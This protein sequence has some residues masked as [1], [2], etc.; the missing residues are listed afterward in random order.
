MTGK[1]KVKVE[2]RSCVVSAVLAIATGLVLALAW[3]VNA[4]DPER[5]L[6][7]AA[8]QPNS[9]SLIVRLN[10]GPDDPTI[11]PAL[12]VTFTSSYYGFPS[13][14]VV[15]QLFLG[16]V[17]ADEETGEII[18]ELAT[19]WEMSSDATVFTFTLRSD[20]T[21]TDGSPV[22]AYDVRYG[23]LRSLDPDTNAE[24]E[25]P[26]FVIQNA[27]EYNNGSITDPNQVG[28][29]VLN[30]TSMRFTLERPAA[31]LPSVLAMPLAHAMPAWAITAHPT[32]WTEPGNIVTNGPY[33]LTAWSHGIS[34]ILDK[35]TSYH[36]A[37][38]VQIDR[39]LFSMVDD[40]TAWG[41]YLA[42]Q[43]DSVIV[44][45]D[46]W[47]AAQS[48]PILQ[49]EIHYAPYPCTYYYGFN[50]AKPPFDDLLVRKAFIA[51]VDR[52][53]VVDN[54]TRYAQQPALTFT[55][56][57]VFGHVDGAAEAVGIPYDPTQAQQWLAAAGYPNGQGLPLITLMYNTLSR[58]EDIAEY[59]RQNW[60]DNLGVTVVLSDT[61]WEDYL[62]LLQIDPP[63]VWRLGW[64]ADHY[65]AYDF[66]YDAV[67]SQRAS[68]G[69]W[70][71]AAYDS[72]L[73][74]A[75]QTADPDT[76]K[77]L[78]KQLEEILVETDAIMLPIY[79]YAN[80]AA[81]K[82][83]LE[84]THNHGGFGGRIADWRI[85]WRL[86]LPVVLRGS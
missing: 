61:N 68:H 38:N 23:I 24:W 76:R 12:S 27:E 70:S 17:R 11:D 14:F 85:A 7:D 4:Q 36:D 81:T 15:N 30:S 22:T 43:L 50:T 1:E 57:G 64:C 37:A 42:G 58:H 21:W 80:G 86:F 52:Q 10:L 16:L 54:V 69:G 49:R 35:N 45:E 25:Y 67:N 72:L 9:P 40:T 46:Q 34:M 71:N 75:A 59:V 5:E 18:P 19:A 79:Y 20:V 65:D 28:I 82:P 51:A 62:D 6:N 77:S 56:P 74:L 3:A 55:P 31:Y 53:G 41:M 47:N 2:N 83:Y 66:L 48:D 39:V 13:T 73:N 33:R 63:Q 8:G 29:T 78:Y 60:T 32:D 26:L 84:R 44:P